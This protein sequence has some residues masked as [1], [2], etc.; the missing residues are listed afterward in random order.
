MLA[1]LLFHLQRD[2]SLIV[3]D[4]AYFEARNHNSKKEIDGVSTEKEPRNARND[5]DGESP[6]IENADRQKQEEI[7]RAKR[8]KLEIGKQAEG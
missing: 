8:N 4:A 6:R 3:P 1:L 2:C 7:S 5:G